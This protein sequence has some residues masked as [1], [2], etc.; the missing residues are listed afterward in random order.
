M[1]ILGLGDGGECRMGFGKDI[2]DGLGLLVGLEGIL[3]RL[4]IVVDGMEV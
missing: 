1:E 2:K 4:C 3:G